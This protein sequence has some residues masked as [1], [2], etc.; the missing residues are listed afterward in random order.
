MNIGVSARRLLRRRGMVQKL[1]AMTYTILSP[2]RRDSLKPK[3]YR[4]N[5][6]LIF[7]M[8]GFIYD[9]GDRAHHMSMMRTVEREIDEDGDEADYIPG[10]GEISDLRFHIHEVL[11]YCVFYPIRDWMSKW[12]GDNEVYNVARGILGFFW[13]LNCGFPARDVALYTVWY[14]RGCK[15]L[16][17]FKNFDGDWRMTYP[18]NKRYFSG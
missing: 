14:L 7:I 10:T 12:I 1:E 18:L 2:A 3:K 6:D 16:F 15:P 8:P 5:D 17:V 4:V 9:F 11:D 13:G